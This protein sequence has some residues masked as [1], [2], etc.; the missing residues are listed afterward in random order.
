MVLLV[1]AAIA[2][3]ADVGSLGEP[4]AFDYRCGD[5]APT[6]A[7]LPA[8]GWQRTG[9]GL[10][11][12]MAENTCWLRVDIA[13]FAPRVLRVLGASFKKDIAVYSRDGR[14][15]AAAR[16]FGDR[17]Q[18]IVGSGD[19]KGSML[20]PTLRAEDG[21]VFLRVDRGRGR[22]QL[23]AVDLAAAVQAER[24]YDFGH[25]AQALLEAVIALIAVALGLL[26]RDRGQF[27]FAATFAGLAARQWLDFNLAASLTPDLASP[28]FWNTV[29][30]VLGEF[31]TALNLLTIIIMLRSRERVPRHHA[32]L[33]VGV[34]LIVFA[35]FLSIHP[36]VARLPLNGTLWLFIW[37]IGLAASWR[38]WRQGHV[39]GLAT[40]FVFGAYMLTW[41]PINLAV[42]ARLFIDVDSRVFVPGTFWVTLLD[43]TLPL[44]FVGGMVA[45][46]IDHLRAT[47]RLREDA[48]RLAEQ[49]SRARSEAAL[50]RALAQAQ[51]DARAAAEG[52]N[53]AKSAFLA[54][55]SHEIRTP[56][57]GIIGMSGLLLRSKLD[58]DQ[59]ELATTI[60][61]SGDALLAI[62]NDI[63]DF[64]KIEAGRMEM[65][66][67]PFVVR[68]CIDS[69]LAMVSTRAAEKGLRLIS[70][71]DDDV[72]AAVAGDV[73]RLRQ[74]LLNLLSNA[75]KFTKR[76]EVALT[77]QRGTADQL[78]FTVRDTGIGM[79][80]DAQRKLFH[81]F[82]QADASTARKYGGTG[83]GL[84]ISKRLVE[85]MG[86]TMS[87]TSAG[88]GHGS[89]FHFDI[90]AQ[91]VPVPQPAALPA[92]V[93]AAM[94]QRHPLRILLAEDN[95]VNQRLAMRLL[96]LMGYSADLAVNGLEAL[97]AIERQS[98]DVV[99][100]D[101]QM[102]ELDGLE[103][104]RRITARWPAGQRPR[105]VAMTANAMAGD[106]EACLAAGMDDY[107][108][109]PI[110]VERLV[111]AL[112]N[113]TA[114]ED[115]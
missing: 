96:A 8:D 57:N 82:S 95:V 75:V 61:D 37:P 108:T 84:A 104:T 67:V 42:W 100:M 5:A 89:T 20:F 73:T 39:I 23:D 41:A 1:L 52:A 11:P 93:D 31:Q 90:R 45:R 79:S 107:V 15:L 10:L 63:L 64:S 74:V 27:V 18:V 58:D 88:T 25:F 77:A 13:A 50:Q 49:E 17:Q 71:V 53:E 80:E 30:I 55:M 24:D 78:R 92:A 69:A 65:E 28:A 35:A 48:V 56:M 114:R 97:E 7:A 38:V 43:M 110:R 86:G 94:A 44:V 62:I 106:R 87:A 60:H 113:V 105:I 32:W 40:L 59:R 103:A 36:A 3:R 66:T 112:N 14:P 91:P 51:G 109:K 34:V 46:A 83:L 115:R 54:T 2:V 68:E 111:E 47:Q 9:N 70:T 22:L 99:L 33:L 102:P 85:L 76:G 4:V 6:P 72:P 21:P 101:A 19:G 26:H 16:D 81:S 29:K 98:Y 12:A